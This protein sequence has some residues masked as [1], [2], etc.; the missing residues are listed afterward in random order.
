M[1]IIRPQTMNDAFLVSS[2]VAETDYAAWDSGTTYNLGDR[3]LVVATDVHKVY[4]SLQAA[5]LNHD[6]QTTDTWWLEVSYSNRWKMFDTYITSQTSNADTID[7]VMQAVG[8]VDSVALLN[9]SASTARVQMTDAV[10]GL[11]FDTTYD[12]TST[13]GIDDWYLYFYEPIVRVQDFVTSDMAAYNNATVQVTLTD[14]GSDVLCG[15][16][17]LGLSRDFG[18]TQYGARVGIQDYSIKQQDAFGNYTILE[19]AFNKNANW[20]LHMDNN[21]IDQFQIILAGYRATPIVYVG[22]DTYG[23]TIIYGF[24]KDFSVTIAYPLHSVCNLELEGLT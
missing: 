20:S 14:V 24:Y 6:P 5:N 12:L 9:I 8:R 11:V 23:S 16:L 22:A 1:R 10:D 7:V 13:A 15:A 18:H 19:R 17:V 4:E 3:V 2:N 21:E